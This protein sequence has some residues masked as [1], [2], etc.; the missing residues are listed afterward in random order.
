MDQYDMAHLGDP[1]TT[2]WD[3]RGWSGAPSPHLR[4]FL[5]L[6]G[7]GLGVGD[8]VGEPIFHP[9]DQMCDHHNGTNALS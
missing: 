9:L 1:Y 7:R 4:L 8:N 2:P 6:I 3:Q 5:L